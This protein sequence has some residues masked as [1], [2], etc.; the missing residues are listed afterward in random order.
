MNK[1]YSIKYYLDEKAARWEHITA[2]SYEEA[3]E[4][5]QDLEDEGYQEIEILEVRV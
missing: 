5:K 1:L 3:L 2:K 4:I